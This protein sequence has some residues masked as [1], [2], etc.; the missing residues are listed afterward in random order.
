MLVIMN[1]R[2]FIVI[3]SD[4]A[5][6]A[7]RQLEVWSQIEGSA[8][9]HV[10][11]GEGQIEKVTQRKDYIPLISV[12]FPSRDGSVTF[13]SDGFKTGAFRAIHI[14]HGL[15][16]LV[17]QWCEQVAADRAR[18]A[19]EEAVRL[20]FRELAEKYNIPSSKI[21]IT[22]LLPILLKLENRE[23]LDASEVQWLEEEKIFN[24]LATY[25]LPAIPQRPRC[26]EPRQGMSLFARRCPA[27]KGYCDLQQIR[28]Q[29]PAAE[30][31]GLAALFT[32]RGG[33]FATCPSL[34]QPDKAQMKRFGY[35]HTAF[36]RITFS[37]RSVTKR[38]TL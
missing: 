10:Q 33:A 29:R 31:A 30:P 7:E 23:D 22:P 32:S 35:R 28:L 9:E 1:E 4:F 14:P 21:G 12:R 25:F 3:G 38:E 36:T 11:F 34:A 8:V 17:S 5:A 6:F 26:L 13:N 24:L 2:I 15:V 18:H 16:P 27:W 37:A 20:Q 19:A